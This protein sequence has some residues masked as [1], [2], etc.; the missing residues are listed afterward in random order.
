MS[1]D[2]LAES[3]S[4]C[5]CAYNEEKNIAKCIE[6]ALNFTEKHY[7][8]AYEI[9]VIDN[10]ST[11]AT[12]L[13]VKEYSKKNP[14][15]KLHRHE[16]NRLYSGSYNSAF[17]V[18][19]GKYLAVIDGDYQHTCNDILKAIELIKIRQLAATYC[20]KKNRKD[21]F[22]RGL[23]SFGLKKISQIL[24]GHDL[25]DIN[26]G[27]RVFDKSKIQ[28]V[29]I[30]EK[31]NTVGPELLCE[32]RKN[33]CDVGEIEVVHF[34]REK[35]EGMHGSIVPL[36]KNTKKFLIYLLKLRNKY[37]NKPKIKAYRQ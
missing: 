21:G 23:F 18:S 16:Q 17:S 3:I 14:Q 10:A 37:G 6:D 19:R 35:G 5:F 32:L 2:F 22:I 33:N 7:P 27:Y 13:I 8:S 9:I 25:N 11:D 30:V 12:P 15:I 36:L 34:P 20:W 29:S 28:M 1:F 31:I 26:G 24:I 4:I